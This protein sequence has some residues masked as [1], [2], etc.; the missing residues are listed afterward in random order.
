MCGITGYVGVKSATDCLLDM[1]YRLQYRGYDS[2]GV[3]VISCRKIKVCKCK[4]DIS[5]LKRKIKN[6][7]LDSNAGIGHTRWATHGKPDDVNAHPHLSEDK[8]FAVVHNGIIENYLEIKNMLKLNG[9]SFVSQTDTEV[10]ANLLQYYYK[11]DVFEALVKT[12]KLLKGSYAIGVMSVY[13]PETLFATAKDSPLIA[14]V[15]ENENFVCSDIPAILPLTEKIYIL[16]DGEF[17]IITKSDIKITDENKTEIEKQFHQVK[18][19]ADEIGKEG[20]DFYMEKEIMQQPEAIRK[21]I[22]PRI[23]N[24]RVFIEEIDAGFFEGVEH[25]HIVAC[26]SAFN[27]G[28]VGKF[29]IEKFARINVCVQLASEFRYNNPIIGNNDVVIAISQSGETS[30]TLAAVKYAKQ[31]NIKTLAITNVKDSSLARECDD[32]IYTFAG[33]EIAVATTKGYITQ[34]YV[35]MLISEFL[36]HNKKLHYDEFIQKLLRSAE[37]IEELISETDNVKKM[38]ELFFDTKNM[39][40]I[41]RGIDGIISMEG[42]LKLKEISY[43]HAESYCA[44]ELKHGTLAL[45]EEGTPVI[46]ICTQRKLFD[47]ML[48]N[49]KEVKARGGVV[50][51]VTL[52]T[53]YDVISEVDE[54]ILIPDEGDEIS[55]IFAVIMLQLFAYY[56][57]RHRGIDVDKPRNLAKSVTVE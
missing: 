3:G 35:L 20:F 54:V 48:S 34:V 27:A 30:D 46:A 2:A 51:A 15:G 10:I 56:V 18:Y 44:G 23:I 37:I 7:N 13:Q 22:T 42:A 50:I 36:A 41:G 4:G 31:S 19:K 49:I 26:G 57:S 1:L 53:M 21:T 29:Y 43:I 45:I 39:F 9:Y 40:F 52:E 24:G 14:G 25:I 33:P 16:N 28:L 17:A 8:T 11:G 32:V 6:T 38:A 12:T 47:K 5:N 55:P